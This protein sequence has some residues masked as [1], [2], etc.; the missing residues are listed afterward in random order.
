MLLKLKSA[1]ACSLPLNETKIF[2]FLISI[3][4]SL[5]SDASCRDCTEVFK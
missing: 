2:H 5:A 4:G 1:G 3:A